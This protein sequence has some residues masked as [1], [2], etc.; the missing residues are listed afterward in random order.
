M[1][2]LLIGGAAIAPAI[3]IGEITGNYWPVVAIAIWAY[4]VGWIEAQ[5]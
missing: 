2:S 4:L 1:K 3:A 5:R